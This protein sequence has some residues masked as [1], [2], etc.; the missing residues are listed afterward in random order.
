M[1]ERNII[2]LTIIIIL[3]IFG[4]TFAAIHHTKEEM[5]NNLT[6]NTTYEINNT[7]SEN[8]S[9]NITTETSEDD[10]DEWVKDEIGTGHVL[11]DGNGRVDAYKTGG[12]PVL[13]KKSSKTKTKKTGGHKIPTESDYQG[14][15]P[16]Y[17]DEKSGL[18]KFKTADG[19]TLIDYDYGY[20]TGE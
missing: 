20:R 4:V 9:E 13:V 16:R 7:T 12:D 6:N 8:L 18:W 11:T 3:L 14:N 10:D 19:N 5:R 1:E 15:E 17:Y 2:I